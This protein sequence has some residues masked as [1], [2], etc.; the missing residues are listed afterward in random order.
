[1]SQAL[2]KGDL[3]RQAL[4]NAAMELFGS[5]GY[6]ATSVVEITMRA[7]VAQGTF[8]IYFAGKLEIYRALVDKLTREVRRAIRTKVANLEHRLDIEREG[9]K[10]YFAYAKQNRSLYR[11]IREAEFVDNELYQRHYRSIAE[12]YIAGLKK[13]MEAGQIRSIDPATVAYCLMG[14]GEFMGL[15]WILWEKKEV[16]DEDLS[17]LMDFVFHGIAPIVGGQGTTAS[18]CARVSCGGGSICGENK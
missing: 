18:E 16:S 7:G 1:M 13:A 14:M 15:R 17:A 5:K 6:H 2:T 11:I 10:A 12:G 4:L 3:T 9:F 8:Y